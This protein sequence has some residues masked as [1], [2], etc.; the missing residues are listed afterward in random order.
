MNRLGFLTIV[1]SLAGCTYYE[2]ESPPKPDVSNPTSTLEAS[3]TTTR[4]NKIGA[5]FWKT[6]DFLAVTPINLVTARVPPV[7]GL[8][9]A[10]DLYNG[11]TD[12]NNGKKPSIK[13]KAAYDNDSLYILIT[14][15]DTLFN[16]SKANWLFNGPT[17]PRKPGST[18]GW[19]SQRSEDAF[20][21]SFDMTGGQ[22]DVW[23]WSLALS[24]PLGY[25]IDRI[26]TSLGIQSDDAGNKSYVRNTVG[27]T[28]R[29]GPMFDW[30]GTEQKFNRIPTAVTVLDPGYYLINKKIF[31]GDPVLGDVYFQ[32]E[33]ALCH[34]TIGDGS[35]TTNPV[36]IRLNKPGQFDRWTRPSLDA[37]ALNASSHEGAVHYPVAEIDRTNLF[38]RLRG[39][40]GVP[41]YY[42]QNPTGSCS[43]VRASSNV[44]LAK[45]EDYNVKGYSVLLIRKLNTGNTD[46]IAF[47]PAQKIYN[48]S[49]SVTHND[50]LNKIGI[51]NQ[52]LT[53]KTKK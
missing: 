1:I 30:D 28:N 4:P 2:N 45:I 13:M 34:G 11:L 23:N 41:G 48:F 32:A 15:K 5:S 20:I 12:F 7:D 46:D 14:W 50:E 51:N 35:G 22:R 9:N 25:A 43:D 36:G 47:D 29:S 44:P 49:F 40:S 37:F 17:D 27:A 24:E 8:F 33:C 3:Y 21:F 26:E 38:A 16:A 18:T 39:F 42:L 10:S 6:A 19:T 31:T 53:F 52:Q